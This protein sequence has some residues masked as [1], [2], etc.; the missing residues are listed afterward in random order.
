ME[1]RLGILKKPEIILADRYESQHGVYYVPTD[2]GSDPVL[3]CMKSNG[4]FEER[5]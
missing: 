4:L 2:H 5:F 3:Q 1:N